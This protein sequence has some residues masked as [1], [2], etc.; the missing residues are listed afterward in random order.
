MGFIPSLYRLFRVT[1]AS[2]NPVSDLAAFVRLNWRIIVLCALV[3]VVVAA[4]MRYE[5]NR[6][7]FVQTPD[8]SVVFDTR[9]GQYC[10]PGPA[11]DNPK[12]ELPR[13]ADLAKGWW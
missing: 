6:E 8:M 10:Y 5:R 12:P 2:M 7:R 13:C 4:V 11:P 3:A 9:T 1:W